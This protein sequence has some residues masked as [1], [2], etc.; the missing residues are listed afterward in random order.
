MLALAPKRCSCTRMF[1]VLDLPTYP[2]L[3]LSLPTTFISVVG[4]ITALPFSHSL[5]KPTCNS[6]GHLPVITG[7]TPFMEWFSYVFQGRAPVM[8][9]WMRYQQQPRLPNHRNVAAS[10]RMANT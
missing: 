8:A 2:H 9:C 10:R 3:R 4:Y 5:P 7:I 6:C 1:T